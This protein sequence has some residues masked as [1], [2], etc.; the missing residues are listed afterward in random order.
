[1]KLLQPVITLLFLV[2][3]YCGCKKNDPQV[4]STP[5]LTSNR[6]NSLT[7]Y[8][9]ENVVINDAHHSSTEAESLTPNVGGPT[10]I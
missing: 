9:P 6:M 2:F 1:M 4:N 5:G 8:S 3:L 10:I 7:V